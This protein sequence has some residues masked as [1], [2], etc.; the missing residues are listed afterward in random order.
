[1]DGERLLVNLLRSL[2]K[3]YCVAFQLLLNQVGNS[4]VILKIAV[5]LLYCS[6]MVVLPRLL[7]SFN[8][9]LT[10]TADIWCHF[11]YQMRCLQA[12]IDTYPRQVCESSRT[13]RGPR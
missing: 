7:S 8:D 13:S 3:T 11:G 1:M 9:L 2:G 6:R 12:G 4:L 5:I 10:Q